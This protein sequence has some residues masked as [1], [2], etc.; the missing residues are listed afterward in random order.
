MFL[1]ETISLQYIISISMSSWKLY[2]ERAE[3]GKVFSLLDC[4]LVQ[5]FVIIKYI[6]DFYRFLYLNVC[7]SAKMVVIKMFA[8]ASKKVSHFELVCYVLVQAVLLIIVLF[9]PL[10]EGGFYR[11]KKIT[12]VR[13]RIMFSSYKATWLKSSFWLHFVCL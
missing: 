2:R 8:R 4:S 5:C 3:I 13:R 9:A 7:N 12:V 1:C 10:Q 6:H 11:L